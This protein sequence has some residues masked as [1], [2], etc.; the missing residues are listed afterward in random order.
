MDPN[1][2]QIAD[3]IKAA[4][5]KGRPHFEIYNDL[6]AAGWTEKDLEPFLQMLTPPV[7]DAGGKHGVMFATEKFDAVHGPKQTQAKEPLSM[8]TIILMMLG[9]VIIIVLGVVGVLAVQKA[10]SPATEEIAPVDGEPTST[11]LEP[12]DTAQPADP[13]QTTETIPI[14]EAT[15]DPEIFTLDT[16]DLYYPD[17][18]AGITACDQVFPEAP[19]LGL[20]V[21]AATQEALYSEVFD[22]LVADPSQNFGDERYRASYV[23]GLELQS[24]EYD[25]T[26]GTLT[27]QIPGLSTVGARCESTAEVN[28]VRKTMEALPGVSAVVLPGTTW[29]DGEQLPPASGE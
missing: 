4:D 19:T 29:P 24:L 6:I 25:S 16:F 10:P 8:N 7:P 13:V 21:Q 2:Q 1:Q 17:P 14:E 15:T 28:Q 23:T 11:E 3:F 12:S 9:A 20:P 22:I 5:A 27:L 26:T 18:A